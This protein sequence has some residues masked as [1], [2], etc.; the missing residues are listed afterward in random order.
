[1]TGWKQRSC[2]PPGRVKTNNK[3]TNSSSKPKIQIYICKV[4]IK[5]AEPRTIP[6]NNG[7]NANFKDFSQPPPP[8]SMQNQWGGGVPQNGHAPSQPMGP[9]PPQVPPPVNW[10]QHPPQLPSP[11]STYPPHF[12]S[13]PTNHAMQPLPQQQQHPWG[14]PPPQT[15]PLVHHQQPPPQ[16]S[17]YA[18]P[19]PS[20]A[21]ITVTQASPYPTAIY[22][23]PSTPTGPSFW[24]ASPVPTQTP[25]AEAY[26]VT[27]KITIYNQYGPPP[28]TATPTYPTQYPNI[29]MSA[30]QQ[31]P[32]PSQ[33]PPPM[34]IAYQPAPQVNNS[35]YYSTVGGITTVSVA[36]TPTIVGYQA[37]LA[38]AAGGLGPQR[39]A[40]Y[41]QPSQVQS[42][43]PY[44]RSN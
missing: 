23:V 32:H 6:A 27:S 39:G 20:Q 30:P 16:W 24:A 29:P 26:G 35:E 14:Q 33:K 21:S 10:T 19:P 18:S 28:P 36:A 5:R 11:V 7:T 22:P 8:T 15:P 12:G 38:V 9:P 3:Q 1:V 40:L 34:T 41:A 2:V 44:R 31:Q 4:E 42:Y 37:E 17:P 43:H 25:P 13:P